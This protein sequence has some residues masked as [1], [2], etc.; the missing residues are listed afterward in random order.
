MTAGNGDHGGLSKGADNDN[1]QT[2]TPDS[3]NMSGIARNPILTVNDVD[4]FS[5]PPGAAANVV[6]NL[7]TLSNNWLAFMP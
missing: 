1:E 5:Q 2:R 6:S 7:H 4:Q 3:P